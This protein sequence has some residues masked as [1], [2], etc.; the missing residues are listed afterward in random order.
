MNII[1]SDRADRQ[2]A[3]RLDQEVKR[4][5]GLIGRIRLYLARRRADAMLRRVL[6]PYRAGSAHQLSPHLL[7]D[8]GLPPDLRM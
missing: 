4:Q 8:I 3:H 7:K 6:R 2:I 5:L 1:L